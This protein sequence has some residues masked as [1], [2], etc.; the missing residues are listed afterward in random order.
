MRRLLLLH[1]LI[2][3]FGWFP[4]LSAQCD[5]ELTMTVSNSFPAIYNNVDYVLNL[6][7][8]GPETATN[9]TVR[10]PHNL[11]SSANGL[12]YTGSSAT[13]G[14]YD[15]ITLTWSIPALATGS[16]ATLTLTLFTM[17]TGL[18]P[19]YAQ[20][21][22]ASPGDSD[23]QPNNG[24][25]PVA[26]EDDEA[27]VD[28]S[29]TQP[30]NV[31]LSF[32]DV[33]CVPASPSGPPEDYYQYKVLA[34]TT[35]PDVEFIEIAQNANFLGKYFVE[36]GVPFAPPFSTGFFSQASV[37][38][39]YWA[40]PIN[41]PGCVVKDTSS[42]PPGCGVPLPPGNCNLYFYFNDVFC[43][44]GGYGFSITAQ[45]FGEP[46]NGGYTVYINDLLYGSYFT[47]G[48]RYNF[49]L[50]GP[51]TLPAPGVGDLVRIVSNLDPTCSSESLVYPENYCNLPPNTFCNQRSVFPWHEWI[52]RV[53]FDG[54]DQESGKST[55]SDFRL[56]GYTPGGGPGY[57]TVQAGQS[58]PLSITVNYSYIA[59]AESVRVW[60]DKNHDGIF[61]YPTDLIF[62]G[63][64]PSV[65]NG[66]NASSTL[67]ADV[68]IP[69]DA[70]TGATSL[71]VALQR[72]SY[73][74]ACD[75]IPFGEV[76]YYSVKI[77]DGQASSMPCDA[78]TFSV[79]GVDCYDPGTPD[80]T[81]DDLYYI[82]YRVDLPG[83]EGLTVQASG[84]LIDAQGNF[85]FPQQDIQPFYSR[86]HVGQDAVY[87]P[88][89][90]S[91]FPHL[92][93][94]AN[95]YDSS[96]FYLVCYNLD[97][98]VVDAPD[99]CSNGIL[100]A[101][102][103]DCSSS[104]SFPWEDW[105]SNV[106]IGSFEK[107]S[108]KSYFSDFTAETAQLA[109]GGSTPVALTASFSY[110]TYDEYWRIWIDFNHDGLF[111]TPGEVA[112]EGISA[113]SENGT[114]F[115]VFNGNITVPASAL[116]GP[117]HARV[118][119]RRN[120]FAQPCDTQTNGEVEDYTVNIPANLQAEPIVRSK[121]ISPADLADFTLFPNPASEKFFVKMPVSTSP[122]SFTLF[123]Q[124]GLLEKQ[125]GPVA[126]LAQNNPDNDSRVIE[127]D[128][129]TVKNGVYFLKMETQG[130]PPVTKKL[131]V[132]KMY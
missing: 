49:G 7:N 24:A 81:G 119:M 110:F 103:P 97:P 114:P 30:C 124:I 42:A 57:A 48:E 121:A 27:L 60:L 86:G 74:S 78:A 17:Q 75:A 13:A 106:Q 50:F 82:R 21:S 122:V 58:V 32:V 63:Q 55:S 99:P 19:V 105:I 83:S 89:P 130:M 8:N 98:V 22:G 132:N 79:L 127:L 94:R 129:S 25:S 67:Q 70:V 44:D 68:L 9:I 34:T 120:A 51:L 117:A 100:P 16:T 1:F 131:V 20:V 85:L 96:G 72:G 76:E 66:P 5:L 128:I 84:N 104:S 47:Y 56:N 101:P 64:M 37:S 87:G 2:G 36:P 73:P 93:L 108:G 91:R 65:T 15:N 95:I 116:P 33:V 123:N 102:T 45:N 111:D 46:L 43:H 40:R 71:K 118:I 88:I 109:P 115:K 38:T 11:L 3:L 39:P 10:A 29:A 26:A 69:T 126:G 12:V 14:S 35:D 52:S 23:S 54:I 41:N 92:T 125:Y 6:H 61:D 80:G 113:S 90:I 31:S 112:C 18:P 28:V 4:S 77:L 62:E 53:Q 59:Y 107:S